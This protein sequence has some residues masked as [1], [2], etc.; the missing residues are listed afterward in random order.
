[1][2]A[3]Q[4]RHYQLIADAVSQI[5]DENKRDHLISFIFVPMFQKDNYR[6]NATKFREW[7]ERRVKGES[8]KGMNYNPNYL[9]LG[10]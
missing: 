8:I 2:T 9:P 1:M 6:F 5:E 10:V 7:I 3:F 4:K